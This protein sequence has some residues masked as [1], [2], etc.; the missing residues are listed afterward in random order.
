MKVVHVMLHAAVV[1]L[2]FLFIAESV[3]LATKHI[4][5]WYWCLIPALLTSFQL[6]ALLKEKD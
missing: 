6:L 2:P 3:F 4:T 5:S 1:A